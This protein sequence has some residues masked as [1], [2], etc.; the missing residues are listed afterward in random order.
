MRNEPHIE[1]MNKLQASN[2][3]RA[4]LC[5]QYD[6]DAGPLALPSHIKIGGRAWDAEKITCYDQQVD[7][8]AVWLED[9]IKAQNQE[10]MGALDD[11]YQR[12]SMSGVILTTIC[13]PSPFRTHAH[14]VMQTIMK[15]ASNI[16]DIGGE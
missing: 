6:M 12:A 9:Q 13:L 7:E 11:I 4:D 3:G 8:Y 5:F 15:L 16:Q 10:V 2:S 14:V 1:V